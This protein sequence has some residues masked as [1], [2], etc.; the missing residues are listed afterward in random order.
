MKLTSKI[1]RWR[2]GK[3]NMLSCP[4]T[5]FS[6]MAININDSVIAWEWN[7]ASV[8]RRE[9]GVT[10]LL[11]SWWLVFAALSWGWLMLTPAERHR[12]HS[13]SSP[14]PRSQTLTEANITEQKNK[15]IINKMEWVAV[16]ET[17]PTPPPQYVR[18]GMNQRDDNGPNM[19]AYWFGWPTFYG[20]LFVLSRHIYL[21]I[22]GTH[23]AKHA[24]PFIH[25]SHKYLSICR[26]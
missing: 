20:K 2:W 23:R 10:Y 4:F 6:L 1:K 5:L 12:A 26:G 19:A 14:S 24:G 13:P 21:P 17:P 18:A 22:H 9:A 8:C 15:L 11:M 16:E 25:I 3:K 7:S